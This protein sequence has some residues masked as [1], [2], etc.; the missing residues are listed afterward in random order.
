MDYSKSV[1]LNDDTINLRFPFQTKLIEELRGFRSSSQGNCVF[2]REKKIWE[3]ALTE[4]N[5]NWVYAWAK[6][7]GFD[8]SPDIE[9]L[10]NA[11][12]DMESIPYAIELRFGKDQLEIANAPSSLI[13]YVNEHLGGFNHSNLLRLL[14]ASSLLGYSIEP[15]LA[16]VVIQQWGIRHLTLASNREVRIAPNTHTVDDDFISVLKYAVETNR[17]PVVIYEPDLSGRLLQQIEK[18]FDQEDYISVGNNK[19]PTDTGGKK[20]IHTF[21]PIRNLDR[22]PMLVSS[23]G[24]IFGG[25]KQIMTQRTEKIVFISSD[26]YNA[27]GGSGNKTKK[28]PKL[29]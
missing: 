28:V 29:I 20:F 21:K 16:D 12:L 6:A 5:L 11:I 17:L 1:S 18:H 9:T 4:Y 14:D 23:A 7:N 22:I 27:T 13:E 19:R 15:D 8:I 10:N 2:D 24:M 25:D 26:V 3:I